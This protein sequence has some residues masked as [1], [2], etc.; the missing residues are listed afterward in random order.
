MIAGLAKFHSDYRSTGHITLSGTSLEAQSTVSFSNVKRNGNSEGL[1]IECEDN[2]TP[3]LV[4][5]HDTVDIQKIK[6]KLA[7]QSSLLLTSKLWCG[8]HNQRT[9]R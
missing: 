2:E 6:G 3:K 1:N 5:R 8:E 9:W 7:A 4:L